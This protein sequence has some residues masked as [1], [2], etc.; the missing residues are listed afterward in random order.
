M[1]HPWQSLVIP[2]ALIVVITVADVV[3]PVDV[4]LSP[5]LVVAPTTAAWF[6]AR[7]WTTGGIGALTV[8]AQ[9]L[10]RW[11]FGVLTSR[12]SVVQAIALALLSALVVLICVVR[13]RRS[14]ELSQVRSVAEAAQHVLLWPLPNRLGPLQLASLYLAAEDQA[15]IGGDLYAAARTDSASRVMIGDVRGKGLPAIGEAALLL[16][17]FRET[18]HEHAAL[19]DLAAAL[20]RSVARHLA[21]F[22]PEDEAG[23][24]FVTALLLEIP[25]EEP[26]IRMTSCGHPAPLLLGPDN[27]VTVP[28]VSPAPPLGVGMTGMTDP[29]D[30][31]LDVLPFDSGHTLLL[32]TDGVIEA[33]DRDG[34]FYP[35]AQRAAQWTDNTPEALLHHIEQDL[36]AHTGGGLGDD[37]ALIAIRRTP[38][39]ATAG[40]QMAHAKPG[41]S[42]KKAPV[43]K[44]KAKRSAAEKTAKPTPRGNPAEKATGRE[45]RGVPFLGTSPT[46]GF[47]GS[48]TVR[49]SGRMVAASRPLH[50]RL[51]QRSPA[52]PGRVASCRV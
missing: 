50:A 22:A 2:V 34:T 44:T 43:R 30:Y 47:P 31:T 16:G 21:D 1:V 36:A 18:A 48:R 11:R 23:E 29:A 13:D 8:V 10:I 4:I 33:R 41:K 7:P 52:A 40:E 3:L 25:D 42:A 35:F 9:G 32:Y 38:T 24:R 20:E 17:A 12:N 6:G 14:R 39:P 28:D 26:V 15:E 27:T 45:L 51:P 19:P 46:G 49:L 5:L 37:V